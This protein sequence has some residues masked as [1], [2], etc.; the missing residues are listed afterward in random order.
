[1]P[2]GRAFSQDTIALCNPSNNYN[3][4]TEM[5]HDVLSDW[6]LD[7]GLLQSSPNKIYEFIVQIV[8]KIQIPTQR[9]Q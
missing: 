7:I 4:I 8:S 9:K 6:I 2:K 1:M 5:I 3:L